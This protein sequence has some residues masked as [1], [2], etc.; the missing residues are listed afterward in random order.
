MKYLPIDSLL[1]IENRKKFAAKLPPK[2]LAIFHSN[3]EMP[4]SGDA[5]FPFR[6]NAD[7]Y[8]LSGIDQEHTILL[9]F[10]DCPNEG[11]REVLFVRETNET[12]AIWEGHK[13][14]KEEARNASGIQ[15]VLWT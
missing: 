4:Y 5:S 8:Y 3:D 7:L 15:K 10:P 11:L 14:T 13:Y 1:F 2:S 6:Q 9:L 12:I